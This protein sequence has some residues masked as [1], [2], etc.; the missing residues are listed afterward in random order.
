MLKYFA[1]VGREDSW[2][3]LLLFMPITPCEAQISQLQQFRQ[4]LYELFPYSHDSLMDLLDALSGNTT[5]ASPV[6][7]CERKDSGQYTRIRGEGFAPKV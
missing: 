2:L 1:S 7:L 6:E 5:A 4:Q 3:D